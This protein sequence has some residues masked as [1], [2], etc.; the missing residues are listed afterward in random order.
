MKEY[1]PIMKNH[2]CSKHDNQ[3]SHPHTS[4][5][6]SQKFGFLS[7]FHGTSKWLF[8]PIGVAALVWY[9]I[10]VIPKPSRSSYPC[11]QVAGPVAI[12][13]IGV[14]LN[15]LG[16]GLFLHKMQ[17]AL[18]KRR[19]SAA[20]MCLF[21]VVASI[22]GMI[23]FMHTNSNAAKLAI[24][25]GLWTVRLDSANTP[26]GTAKGICPGRV[27]WIRDST[28]STFDGVGSWW[29]PQYNKQPVL[30]TLL[31]RVITKT[32]GKTTITAAWDTLFKNFNYR[33]Y[34]TATGYAHGQKIVVKI[35]LNNFGGGPI[36][37]S[38]ELCLSML[39]Q[40]VNV[41]GAAQTDI[42]IYDACRSGGTTGGVTGAIH[43]VYTYCA[44]EFPNVN[45]NNAGSFVDSIIHY[46]DASI[47]N[48][49]HMKIS[50]VVKN[51]DYYIAMPVLKRHMQPTDA[52]NDANGQ[53]SISLCFKSH[54]GDVISPWADEQLH[55][56]IRDWNHSGPSYNCLVDMEANKYLGGNTLLYVVDGIYTGN[57]WDS[58]PQRWK[59]FGNAYPCMLFA[60]QDPVA[61]ESV[62]IDF[63]RAEWLDYGNTN[64]ALPAHAD[65][66]L[67][68]AAQIGN[69]PSGVHYVNAS[70]GSLGV[71]EHWNNS[72]SKSY[73]RN[74]GTGSGI[75]L[76]SVS[77]S[78]IFTTHHNRTVNSRI[79]I[80]SDAT[81]INVYAPF[82]GTSGSISIVTM[83][84][85]SI[86]SLKT[87]EAVSWY[88]IPRAMLP[89]IGNYVVVVNGADNAF[90]AKTAVT[91][92]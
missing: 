56:N 78:A 14:V 80:K 65:N 84:G 2:R 16:A 30:D 34:G 44:T 83:Q 19:F 25:T 33:K 89:A 45:Y 82:A 9:L 22:V 59:M 41:V 49:E 35:N 75:E 26:V 18:K 87:Q 42:C 47:S 81:G 62:A 32:A 55:S 4:G 37:A 12:G 43:N 39:R 48:P 46:S 53:T 15:W 21:A 73:T 36:D 7:K 8:L 86:A 79:K 28:A 24:S 67:H 61:L 13:F 71:H 27:V 50:Q 74:L 76:L 68:E 1:L 92:R 20:I 10:R 70:L 5:D 11:Q 77:P 58:P 23:S 85:R 91:G 17:R 38:P 3:C 57:R 69:P 31:A 72:H 60:S 52:W 63:L 64:F 29:D 90:E 6:E 54:I 66:H 40:L 51:A 88:R